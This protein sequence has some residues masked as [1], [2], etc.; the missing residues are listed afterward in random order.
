M[1]DAPLTNGKLVARDG[2]PKTE[3]ESE[4]EGKVSEKQ[5]PDIN[6]GDDVGDVLAPLS[7]AVCGGSWAEQVEANTQ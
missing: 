3:N 4:A 6:D 1:R 7:P 5:R 2:E